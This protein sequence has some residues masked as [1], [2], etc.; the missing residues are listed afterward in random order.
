[1]TV[2]AAEVFR[3]RLHASE[4]FHPAAALISTTTNRQQ[5]F[6]SEGPPRVAL[7]GC[8]CDKFKVIILRCCRRHAGYLSGLYSG[9]GDVFLE[10]AFILGDRKEKVTVTCEEG[11]L[12]DSLRAGFSRR[13]LNLGIVNVSTGEDAHTHTQTFPPL[14]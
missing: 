3:A 2:N 13:V 9:A 14:G 10:I 12:G 11:V 8:L 5:E 4:S 1:M 6:I 7:P